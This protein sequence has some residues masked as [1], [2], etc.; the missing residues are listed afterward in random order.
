MAIG[1]TVFWLQSLVLFVFL[2]RNCSLNLIVNI[3]AKDGEIVQQNF[4]ADPEKDYVT[5]DFKNNEGRFVSVFIDFRLKRKIFQVIVLGEM[6][7]AES[8][9]EAMCFVTDLG[10]EEF[11]SSDAMSKLRQKNPSTIR[12]PEE[13]IGSESHNMDHAVSLEATN[14]TDESITHLCKDAGRVLFKGDNPKLLLSENSTREDPDK[15]ELASQDQSSFTKLLKRCKD[16]SEL[17]AECMCRVEVCISW[18]PC[19]LKFCQG[20]DDNGQP[21]EYRCGIKTCGKCH[22]FDFYVVERRHCFWDT[23]S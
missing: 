16:T 11:I 9:Y 7:R 14:A 5:I 18:Y 12:V 2:I 21:T 13:D 3:K 10:E 23:N 8:S 15:L 22:N 6:D 17:S 19:N 1:E 20:Q 4:F